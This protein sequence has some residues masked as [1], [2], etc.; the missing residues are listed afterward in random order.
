MADTSK[1][2]SVK[3]RFALPGGEVVIRCAGVAAGAEVGLR[4]LFDGVEARTIGASGTRIIA[5]VPDGL[6]A[7]DVEV[8]VE[9]SGIATESYAIVVGR[10]LVGDIHMV[11]N[12]AVDPNDGSIVLTRSGSRGQQLPVTLLKIDRAGFVEDFGANV[13][14]PTGLAFDGRGRLYVTNR[15]DGEVVR[16]NDTDSYESVAD[17]LGVATG[18]AFDR[19]GVMFVGDRGGTIHKFDDNGLSRPFASAD[20]SVAAYHLA[21][22][23]DERLYLAAPGLASYDNIYAISSDGQVEIYYRGLGRPQGLA[24]DSNGNLY[25]AACLWGR[26]GIVR[27]SAS[28]LEAELF[29]AGNN[30]VGLCFTRDGDLIAATGDA[31]YSLPAGVYGTLLR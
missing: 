5:V 19:S 7:S 25:A 6:D 8:V 2:L 31:V 17:G 29:V 26:R 22:G 3:P 14:N 30:V 21:F 4:V 20:A 13:L 27:I 1:I 9:S 11:A 15:S 18:L 28:G 24:F 23:P 12:P 16:F 10:K